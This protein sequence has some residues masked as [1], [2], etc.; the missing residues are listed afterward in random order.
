MEYP[1]DLLPGERDQAE[2]MIVVLKTPLNQQVLDEWTGVITAGAIRTSTL[3]CLRALIERAREGR[4]TP[5]RALRVAQARK[6]RHR[7]ATAQARAIAEMPEPGPVNQD[8]VLVHR[9]TDMAKRAS[10]K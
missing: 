6:A 10:R 7:V 9:L 8:N 5:E 4:F 3:G 2:S 1:K